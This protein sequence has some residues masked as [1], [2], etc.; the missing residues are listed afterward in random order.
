MPQ[1]SPALDPGELA[2][3]P[4]PARE[5]TVTQN[6][7][8]T[9]A[10]TWEAGCVP[11][12]GGT[13]R[14]ATFPDNRKGPSLSSLCIRWNRGVVLGVNQREVFQVPAEPRKSSASLVLTHEKNGPAVHRHRVTSHQPQCPGSGLT[15]VPCSVLGSDACVR[16]EELSGRKS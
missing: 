5:L 14:L 16:P 13:R 2:V 10:R 8:D 6:G 15:Q 7:Q 11:C 4:V 3:T 9:S 12:V 1:A